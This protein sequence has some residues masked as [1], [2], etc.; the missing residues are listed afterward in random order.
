MK[1]HIYLEE[2]YINGKPAKNYIKK[3]MKE[4]EHENSLYVLKTGSLEI[5]YSADSKPKYYISNKEVTPHE[6]IDSL[7]EYMNYVK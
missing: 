2:L 5:K 7:I 3:L 4:I 1:T 6:C